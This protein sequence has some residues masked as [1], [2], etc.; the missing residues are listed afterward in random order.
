MDIVMLA[1]LVS[2][3]TVCGGAQVLQDVTLSKMN[4]VNAPEKHSTGD[5]LHSSS[6]KHG[7][8]GSLWSLCSDKFLFQLI[9]TLV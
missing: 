1:S 6:I 7:L 2:I 9:K 8:L 3:V 5:F 4:I